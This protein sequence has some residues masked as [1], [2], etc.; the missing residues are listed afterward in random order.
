MG[1][2]EVIEAWKGIPIR[3][4][5]RQMYVDQN[6]NQQEIAEEL[7]IA[8]PTVSMWLEEYGIYNNEDL[9]T[10]KKFYKNI[11]VRYKDEH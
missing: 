1:L 2:K 5:L 3:E 10:R 6:M 4:L 9:F 11:K 8:Q 7:H